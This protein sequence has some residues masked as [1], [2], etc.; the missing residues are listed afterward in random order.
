MCVFCYEKHGGYFKENVMKKLLIMTIAMMMVGKCWG[1]SDPCPEYHA[2]YV[3]DHGG[4][5]GCN[6]QLVQWNAPDN[7][8]DLNNLDFSGADFTSVP[9]Y[10]WERTNLS[11]L[12][13]RHTKFIG[14]VL[15]NV[16]L[17]GADLKGADLTRANLTNATLINANL[18]GANLTNANLTNANL[19][20]ANL[21]KANLTNAKIDGAKFDNSIINRIT[22]YDRTILKGA[23][24][25]PADCT[26][27]CPVEEC[28]DNCAA[29]GQKCMWESVQRMGDKVYGWGWDNGTC[30]YGRGYPYTGPNPYNV[31][32]KH[33]FSNSTGS[34]YCQ[35]KTT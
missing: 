23:Q 34:I 10:G 14:A 24:C 7:K 3:K 33:A 20:G 27:A 19:T 21:T 8:R 26:I 6:C 16:N 18:T 9:G 32:R 28:Y 4:C 2:Q 5:K 30:Q 17:T 25:D 1:W 13:F 35:G 31:Y 15:F 29:I 12:S 11:G 22:G